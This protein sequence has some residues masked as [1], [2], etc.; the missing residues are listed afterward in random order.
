MGKPELL[1]KIKNR[2]LESLNTDTASDGQKTYSSKP[3]ISNDH[4]QS[5]FE[6]GTSL[7]IRN[8]GKHRRPF[9]QKRHLVV[10]EIA[11]LL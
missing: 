5:S 10:W 2:E 9:F 1:K 3:M 11:R 6:G 8:V 4:C 7:T